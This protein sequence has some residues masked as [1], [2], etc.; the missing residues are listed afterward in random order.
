MARSD[1]AAAPTW[2]APAAQA[3]S[4]RTLRS[5]LEA[6]TALLN[7]RP[8]D[9]IPVAEICRAAGCTP[10]SFYQRFRDK[11]AL[12]HAL[13]ERYQRETLELVDTFLSPDVW[14]GRSIEWLMSALVEGIYYLEQRSIGLR[15]TAVRRS[16]TDEH[17]AER[18]RTIRRALYGQLAACL[19]RLD[20][21]VGHTDPEHGAR[22][23]VRLIQ[24]A[25][26]RHLEGPHLE[27]DPYDARE[28]MDE[29]TLTSLVY[30]DARP[31]GE[32]APHR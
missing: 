13:H 2:I 24:G 32:T 26:V 29:L 8:L 3:R 18:I 6:A 4:R 14:E 31:R 15:L 7:D 25:S 10:P 1:S 12:F 27:D 11:E 30:L 21:Q 22:F 19:A 5:I 20:A 28:L 9:E 17:F 16:R 23:L